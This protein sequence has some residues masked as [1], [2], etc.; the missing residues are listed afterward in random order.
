MRA[1]RFF[2]SFDQEDDVYWEITFWIASSFLRRLD[3]R[4]SGLCYRSSLGQKFGHR[5]S[6]AQMEAFAKVPRDPAVEH[7]NA[8]K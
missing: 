5:G 7:H 6:L 3:A 4:K 1:P 8:R 2:F